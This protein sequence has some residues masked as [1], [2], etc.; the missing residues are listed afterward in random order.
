MS[1]HLPEFQQKCDKILDLLTSDL[2]GVKTGRA[3]PSMVEGLKIQ[4]YGG[5]WM[6]IRELASISVPDAQTIVISPWDKSIIKEIEKGIA[7]L[8][9]NLNPVVD[10][11]IIRISV[12][13]LTE[14]TRKEMVKLVN[15]KI[16]SHRAMVRQERTHFKKQIEAEKNTAGVSEDDVK[17]SLEKLQKI[18][19]ETTAK[20]DKA[21]ESKEKE[22]MTV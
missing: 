20:I 1:Q 2:A 14:E 15:Q 12:P 18:T 9:Q 4:V 3:K 5:T 17:G 11:D 8:G 19:D 16:E 22:I 10:G 6:E 7:T 13:H 21:Q